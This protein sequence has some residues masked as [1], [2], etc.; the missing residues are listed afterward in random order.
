M[1]LSSPEYSREIIQPGKRFSNGKPGGLRE[2]QHN[3]HILHRRAGSSLAQIVEQRRY[4]K[5]LVVPRQDD[6][7]IVFAPELIGVNLET[8]IH[9]AFRVRGVHPYHAA[10]PG[11]RT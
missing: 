8:G 2:A 1:K 4:G 11:V 3:I 9:A 7:Q 10:F 6:G 5:L